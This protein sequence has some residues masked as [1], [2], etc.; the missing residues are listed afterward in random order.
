[1]FDSKILRRNFQVS[2]IPKTWKCRVFGGLCVTPELVVVKD[3]VGSLFG[4]I[5]A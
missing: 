2:G 5:G 4:G 3:T 1:M